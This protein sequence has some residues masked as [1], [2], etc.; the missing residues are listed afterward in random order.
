MKEVFQDTSA[1][2]IQ[3]WHRSLT[4]LTST[5]SHNSTSQADVQLEA[6]EEIR[7][8]MK[9]KCEVTFKHDKQCF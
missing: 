5:E 7:D 8:L 3:A 2:S 6:N 1:F 9:K 4:L